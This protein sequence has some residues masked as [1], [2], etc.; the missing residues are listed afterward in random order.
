MPAIYVL[1]LYF[2][3]L[4]LVADNHLV[5]A[6]DIIK[7]SKTN[8]TKTKQQRVSVSTLLSDHLVFISV[9]VNLIWNILKHLSSTI[10]Q[11]RSQ[12]FSNNIVQDKSAKIRR[13]MDTRSSMRQVLFTIG[14][15][16]EE[17]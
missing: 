11:N 10:L 15:T 4:P 16:Y 2:S 8:T 6:D 7:M 9:F 3:L 12:K 14:T 1:C 13:F 5:V 17:F